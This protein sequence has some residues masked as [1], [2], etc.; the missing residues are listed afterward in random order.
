[1]EVA[2]RCKSDVCVVALSVNFT[3]LMFHFMCFVSHFTVGVRLLLL[4]RISLFV[5]N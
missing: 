4:Y 5:I 3:I 2:V 1:M